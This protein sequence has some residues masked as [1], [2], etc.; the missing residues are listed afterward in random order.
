MDIYTTSFCLPRNPLTH[1]LSP[2]SSL[3]F[4]SR[5]AS[6]RSVP[7]AGGV[8]GSSSNGA[9][10]QGQGASGRTH[11]NANSVDSSPA[12]S[13]ATN[14]QNRNSS[15]SS[16]STDVGSSTGGP[17]SGGTATSAGSRGS[18]DLNDA[19]QRLCVDAMAAHQCLVSFTPLDPSAFASPPLPSSVPG[20]LQQAGQ[21]GQPQPQ[22]S[23]T[24]QPERIYNF[25]LSGGYQQVMSA[26]G[27]LLR[28]N[29]F[30]VRLFPCRGKQ[31]LAS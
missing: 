31:E 24:A 6:G 2:A 5:D 9:Q 4:G 19:M 18:I 21:Y 17:G 20:Q 8:N 28:D 11:S 25:H 16:R 26:R 30:K 27:S 1:D 23:P 14:I 3:D 12:F 10:R 22:G 7:G 15:S 13:S 29:P